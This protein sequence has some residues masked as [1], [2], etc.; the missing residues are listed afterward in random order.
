MNHRP[1]NILHSLLCEAGTSGLHQER[2]LE[3]DRK[4]E[5]REGPHFVSASCWHLAA[6]WAY[7]NSSYFSWS[8][9]WIQ[10]AVS[11]TSTKSTSSC[12]RSS[13]RWLA[14]APPSGSGSHPA[15][16]LLLVQRHPL[17]LPAP[18]PQKSELQL[19][20]VPSLTSPMFIIPPSLLWSSASWS[21]HLE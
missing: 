6:P 7:H 3:V 21:Y 15:G 9:S 12:C 20:G 4:P 11:P 2:V 16:N 10:P 17:Q 19:F 8:S 1:K 13:G 18:C 14:G 5:E